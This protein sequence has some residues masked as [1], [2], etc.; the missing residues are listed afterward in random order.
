MYLAVRRAEDDA[1]HFQDPWIMAAGFAKYRRASR[2]L[3]D[4][5][6]R[7]RAAELAG[8]TVA[9]ETEGEVVRGRC[10]AIPDDQWPAGWED[11]P[12]YPPLEQRPPEGLD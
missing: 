5:R 4:A 8:D 2:W 10:R 1:A 12:E 11:W 7:Q 6:A 9:A 3:A